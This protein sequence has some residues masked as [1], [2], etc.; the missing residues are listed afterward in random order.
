MAALQ[1]TLTDPL[2]DCPVEGMD[3]PYLTMEGVDDPYLELANVDDP[4][5]VMEGV[6]E[7][8]QEGGPTSPKTDPLLAHIDTLFPVRCLALFQVA[9]THHDKPS[10]PKQPSFFMSI[11]SYT[12]QVP[13]ELVPEGS[14]ASGAEPMGASKGSSGDGSAPS[15]L[16]HYDDF[17]HVMIEFCSFP[18]G[19]LLQGIGRQERGEENP[20]TYDSTCGRFPAG[21]PGVFGEVERS[22]K[23]GS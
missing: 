2:D 20:Q 13:E 14:P 15:V 21:T 19:G 10:M 8:V 12:G 17:W 22:P 23:W 7:S 16:G 11:E 6:D 5:L 1:G 3:D 4:Y 18:K 9:C